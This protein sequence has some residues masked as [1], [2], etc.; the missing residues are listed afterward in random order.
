MLGKTF[1]DEK[2]PCVL[3]FCIH[4]AMV[5]GVQ[6][7]LLNANPHSMLKVDFGFD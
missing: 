1:V 6:A 3:Q 4:T 2:E 7:Q 5:L